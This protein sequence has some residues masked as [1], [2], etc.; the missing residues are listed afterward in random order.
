M[1]VRT[2]GT[3]LYWA[4]GGDEWTLDHHLLALI[5]DHVAV[6]NW[7]RQKNAR[8]RQRP[9]PLSPLAK[10]GKQYGKTDRDPDEVKAYLARFGPAPAVEPPEPSPGELQARIDDMAGIPR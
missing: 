3:C 8:R 5:H 9:K 1:L 6:A 2:H 10:R 4:L 7:Q